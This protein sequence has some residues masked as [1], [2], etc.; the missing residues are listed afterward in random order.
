VL[1]GVALTVGGLALSDE[2][3]VPAEIRRRLRP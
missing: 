3:F 1:G 2:R